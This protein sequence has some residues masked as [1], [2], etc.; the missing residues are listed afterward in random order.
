MSE[1]SEITGPALKALRQCGV[2]ATRMQAGK[3]KVRGGWMMLSP[4][5]TPDILARPLGR[6]CWIET[7]IGKNGQTPEQ[8]DFQRMSQE[9][10][11]EY[12]LCRS[13]DDVLL[14][15]RNTPLQHP[16]Q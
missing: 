16:P 6:M 14:V 5:G 3:V 12:H 1:T 9:W 4:A 15:L 10:G 2:W 11:D 7:K 13:I 8:I